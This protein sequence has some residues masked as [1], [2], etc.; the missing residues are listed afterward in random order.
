VTRHPPQAPLL[1]TLRGTVFGFTPHDPVR[2]DDDVGHSYA[3]LRTLVRRAIKSKQLRITP[4]ATPRVVRRRFPPRRPGWFHAARQNPRHF[5]CFSRAKSRRRV[6]T[7]SRRGCRSC[8]MSGTNF[9]AAHCAAIH[10]ALQVP[11][12]R[13]LPRMRHI[14]VIF[15]RA[16]PDPLL[17]SLSCGAQFDAPENARQSFF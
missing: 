8:R 13:Q 16:I 7:G 5:Q 2:A 11:A 4:V 17:F 12:W 14:G 3:T 6:E 15:C 1:L 9:E 10:P